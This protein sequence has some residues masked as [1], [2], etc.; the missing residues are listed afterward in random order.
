MKNFPNAFVIMLAVILLAW[1]AT[2]LIPSGTYDR[3]VDAATGFEEVLSDSYRPVAAESLGVFDVLMAI[4]RGIAGRADLVILILLVGGGFYVI[5][6]TGALGQG[7]ER[8]ISLLKGK[9]SLALMLVAIMFAAAGATIG[10]QEEIIAMA[11]I[12]IVFARSMGFNAFVA[13]AISY[14]AAVLGAAFSPMNPFAVVV[15]QK[16]A[17]LALL[18]GSGYRLVFMGVALALWMTYIVWYARRNRVS[19]VPMVR[20]SAGLSLRSV[21][22]LVVLVCTFSVVT[23]GLLSLDWDFNEIT[24]CFLAAGIAAGLLSGKGINWTGRTYV[25]GIKEMVFAAVVMGLANA[26]PLILTEGQVI[27]TIIY[28]LFTPMEDLPASGSALGMM[29]SQ[30]LLHFPVSSYS[31]QALLTMPVLVP[32][33]DLVGVSRQVCVLAYQY[34]AVNMDLVVPTN[35]AL[36]GILAIANISY[37]QWLRFIWRPTLLLFGVAAFAVVLGVLTGF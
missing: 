6:K 8:F 25:E 13:L 12:L 3:S 15:A 30:A 11:P 9:E 27:D 35:G 21:G 17:Q 29:F 34:G 23:Y 4:P 18:S 19:P 32:L 31:G 24:A 37:N 28:G 5:E 26:I 2:F 7:L 33:A 14:G 20:D 36:M 10:L 16:E 22:I 1:L